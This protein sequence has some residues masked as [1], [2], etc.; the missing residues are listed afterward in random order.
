[1]KYYPC[2]RCGRNLI[3]KA[4]AEG[5]YW[6][7]SYYPHCHKRLSDRNGSP[8]YSKTIHYICSGCKTGN[9]MRIKKHERVSKN[10]VKKLYAWRCSNLPNCGKLF[11][12]FKSK[13]SSIV[14]ED[15]H[16]N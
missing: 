12:E 3:R 9:L 6:G 2:P 1:M 14:I 11:K 10:E 16:L 8:Y 13:P 5:Y 7:C 15:N 4:N